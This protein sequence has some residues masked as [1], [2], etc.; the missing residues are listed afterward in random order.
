MAPK[1]VDINKRPDGGFYPAEVKE[2]R[3]NP[4][5]ER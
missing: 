4:S 5:G 2:P 3:I 1:R